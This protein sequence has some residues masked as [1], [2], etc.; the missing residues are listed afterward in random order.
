MITYT[1]TI[2]DELDI[3]KKSLQN[4]TGSLN[5][6]EKLLIQYDITSGSIDVKNFLNNSGIQYIS[7]SFDGDYSKMKNNLL[8]NVTTPWVFHLDGD[9]YIESGS[10]QI[11]RELVINNNKL[12]DGFV[13]KRNDINTDKN[14]IEQVDGS[15]R[16]FKNRK[17][18]KYEGKIHEG[19]IGCDSI[20]ENNEYKIQHLRTEQQISASINL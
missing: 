5:E 16:L 7:Y 4:I 8:S 2:C 12:I 14:I 19:I 13:C 15:I 9:E 11:N 3:L 20:I 1:I 18:I 10:L 17:W 6:N